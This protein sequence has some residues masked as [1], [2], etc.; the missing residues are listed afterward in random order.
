MPTV[1]PVRDGKGADIVG[2]RNLDRERQ[3]TLTVRP[4]ASD[5][6]TMANL[7]WSFADSHVRI[8]KG[9]WARETTVRE[10]PISKTMAGVNMRLTARAPSGNS[11]G[12]G[13]PN[14]PLC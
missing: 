1:E 11:I 12:I 7:K 9:G 3:D 8:E 10:L 14:G 4:S 5:H 6:G 13:R 2:P